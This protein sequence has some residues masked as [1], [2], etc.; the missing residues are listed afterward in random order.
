MSE[1]CC[2]DFTSYYYLL[3]YPLVIGGATKRIGGVAEIRANGLAT[4]SR[5]G[6][7]KG[8]LSLSNRRD[9]EGPS[10]LQSK[11]E[12]WEDLDG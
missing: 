2:C 8:N 7:F 11:T 9:I 12:W 6:R 3:C 1:Q 4:L 10:P 5:E